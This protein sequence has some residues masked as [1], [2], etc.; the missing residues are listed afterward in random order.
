MAGIIQ[1]LDLDLEE[2]RL[3]LT[4]A[5]QNYLRWRRL[6]DAKRKVP[7]NSPAEEARRETRVVI[8]FLFLSRLLRWRWTVGA[9][10]LCYLGLWAVPPA[11]AEANPAV[12]GSVLVEIVTDLGDVLGVTLTVGVTNDSGSDLFDSVLAVGDPLLSAG[13][14]TSVHLGSIQNGGGAAGSGYL[15]IS[16]QTH[17]L[18][19][20]G[21]EPKTDLTYR[22]SAGGQHTLQPKL[23]YLPA[24][25]KGE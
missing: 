1:E 7:S 2:S 10:G 20:S 12:R 4:T 15:L 21:L 8:F 24:A 13:A 25:P 18:W 11:W 14:A 17:D 9:L 3:A 16:R 22:D 5:R 23:I 19:I 6:A